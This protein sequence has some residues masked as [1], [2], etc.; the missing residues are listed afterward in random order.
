MI[1]W[2]RK[3]QFWMGSPAKVGTTMYLKEKVVDVILLS[4]VALSAAALAFRLLRH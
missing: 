3:G 4:V 2:L 1:S